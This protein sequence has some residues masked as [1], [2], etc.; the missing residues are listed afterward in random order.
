WYQL[1]FDLMPKRRRED[2]YD[3]EEEMRAL[4]DACAGGRL[5][6]ITALRRMGKTSLLLTS[7]NEGKLP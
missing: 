6:V 1:L 7:L 5:V 2:L 4:M 3:F